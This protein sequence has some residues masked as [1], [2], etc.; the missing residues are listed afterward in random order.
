[1]P[2]CLSLLLHFFGALQFSSL[3]PHLSVMLLLSGVRVA[4][5]VSFCSDTSS[6][7]P[8]LEVSSWELGAQGERGTVSFTW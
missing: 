2:I 6:D 8:A 4:V 1:M 5:Q 3:F 7:G